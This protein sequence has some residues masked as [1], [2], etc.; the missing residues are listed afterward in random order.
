MRNEDLEF[1]DA[2]V[3]DEEVI[4]VWAG[5]TTWN[6]LDALVLRWRKIDALTQEQVACAKRQINRLV[7]YIQVVESKAQMQ[8]QTLEGQMMA[9]AEE[10]MR[11]SGTKT[12]DLP[13]GSLRLRKQ[14]LKIERDDDKLLEYL[15]TNTDTDLSGLVQV[16]EKPKWAEL[17]K[18]LEPLEI[19][20]ET[21]FVDPSGEV[22]PGVKGVPQRPKLFVGGKDE[23]IRETD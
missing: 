14:P 1:M 8:Q 10:R 13:N 7:Q 18:Y 5:A 21:L 12:L 16:T 15:K 20:G 19:D 23:P 11:L 17:K 6:E 22:V 3:G 4:K 2:V 9:F